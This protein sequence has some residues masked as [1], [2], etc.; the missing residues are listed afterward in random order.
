MKNAVSYYSM[1]AITKET[2]STNKATRLKSTECQI[3]TMR[4]KKRPTV[5][6][7]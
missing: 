5:D 4:L 3:N 6:L 2:A 7:L 1:L